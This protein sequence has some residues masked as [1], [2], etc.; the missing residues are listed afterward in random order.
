MKDAM[1]TRTFGVPIIRESIIQATL[2]LEK[3]Y[4]ITIRDLP[5]E[6]KPRERIVRDG[7]ALLSM[8]ELLSVIFNT[9]SKKED[10][11]SMSTRILK[12]YGEKSIANAR[13]P[14]ELSVDLDIPLSRAAQ[15]V[16][17][18]ELGRRLFE[19]NPNGGKVIRTAKDV[20]GYTKSMAD[21]PKE[22]LR[23]IYLNSHYKVIHDEVISIGT[24]D[25]NII[26]PREVYRPALEYA[27]VAV[28]LVHNHPSGVLKPSDDDVL[29]TKQLIDAGK[30]LGIELIDHVVVSRN[31]FK[32]IIEEI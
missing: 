17:I 21:L 14:K 13:N 10:V 24:I 20:Y 25:A 2:P 23:G 12:E 22:H 30:L 18:V 32:S 6:Q 4:V 29:V 3:P 7:A 16:A 26:H 1:Y 5:N 31:G 8:P 11:L 28:I 19:R 15:L 27:A 9:G